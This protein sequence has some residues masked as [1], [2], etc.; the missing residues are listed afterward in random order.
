MILGTGVSRKSVARIETWPSPRSVRWLLFSITANLK[1]HSLFHSPLSTMTTAP[2]VERANRQIAHKAQYEQRHPTLDARATKSY[3]LSTYCTHA[4][5][6][7]AEVSGY[8]KKRWRMS[9]CLPDRAA[10]ARSSLICCSFYTLCIRPS[11]A[12][13]SLSRS[14]ARVQYQHQLLPHIFDSIICP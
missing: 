3:P 1:V 8:F 12:T 4:R 7:E 6:V 9:E 14:L 2:I 13:R 10:R 5:Q 11:A